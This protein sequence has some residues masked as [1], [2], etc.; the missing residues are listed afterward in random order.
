MLAAVVLLLS[1][2]PAKPPDPARP[3]IVLVVVDTL[4]ADHLGAYG[5]KP[6]TSP[7][8][9]TLA[10]RGVIFASAWGAAPWT[11]PSVM[12]IATGRTPS[13]HRVENDGLRLP[14]DIPTLSQ[15]LKE[16]GYATGGFVSHIYVTAPYGFERGFERFEDFGLTRPG[17]RLESRFEPPADR[18]TDTALDWLRRQ[19]G[20]PVFL[21]VHY[22]DPHWP[23]EPPEATRAL[24]PAEYHG[25]LD[26]T[27]DSL[28]R[29]QD[30]AVPLPDDYRAFLLARYDGEIRFVDAQIGRLVEGIEK[31]GRSGRA[32][33]VVTADHGE[34]FKDHGS[35]GHGRQMYEEV[36]HVPL[37]IVPP[38]GA[39]T[40]A[41]DN[42]ADQRPA[43]HRVTTPVS[44][45]DL[46]PTFAAIAG[47]AAPAGVEGRSLLPLLRGALGG[48]DR[49]VI[50]ETVR[51][52][53]YRRAVREG[54]LKL[55]HVMDESRS[56][57]YDLAADPLEQHDLARARPDDR[58]R[59][60]RALFARPDLLAGGWNVRWRGDGRGQRFDGR[61]RTSGIF[62]S[63]VPL[64]H[65][66][67]AYR[68]EQPDT[69]S[70]ADLDEKGENGLVFTVA[71]ET[72]SVTFDLRVDGR[73]RPEQVRLGREGRQAAQIP[74]TLDGTLGGGDALF[75]PPPD[76]AG[77]SAR[78]AAAH[79][80]RLW[81]TRPA[82]PDQPVT[83]DEE[84]RE[85]LRSLGYID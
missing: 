33:V 29:F 43:G 8:I 61:I 83:L 55:I 3:D 31:A 66:G 81:R 47:A 26:A 32:W 56:E 15:V 17:Y 39:L 54:D 63:V 25:A 65:D 10:S 6:P 22:F 44:G 49:P 68:L 38:R 35:I 9:D 36:L 30:P 64:S 34:E 4:R 20:R 7:Q 51:L 1:G 2:C 19:G 80:F 82:A 52:N 21:M 5:Y 84:T 58:A 67:G 73:Q 59:L 11:L 53:A 74:L 24:F 12:S 71:P 70:F 45:I 85:R 79:G 13:S 69:L 78:T 16:R 62:R 23:Y 27:W 14:S 41:P 57:L 50:S 40:G 46:L 76:I 75:A 77:R 48:E 37:V 72:A 28:S 42:G 18:V 60:T